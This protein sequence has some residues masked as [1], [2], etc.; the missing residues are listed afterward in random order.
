MDEGGVKQPYYIATGSS[1][2]DDRTRVLKYGDMFAIFNRYGDIETTGLDEQGIFY[3]G[4]RIL[5][6]LEVYLGN[7]K[8]LLLS[9]TVKQDNSLFTADLS[10]VDLSRDGTVV[11]PRDTLHLERRQFLWRG[12]CYQ[13]FELFNYGLNPVDIGLEI[14]FAADFADIFEVRGTHRARKGRPLPPIVEE[15]GVV[16]G[17]EGL[18]GKLR[19]TRLECR[20]QPGKTTGSSFFFDVQL[21]PR[22]Q[23]AITL[24]IA[25]KDHTGEGRYVFDTALRASQA[26]HVTEYKITSSNQEFNDWI[27][28]SQ[29]DIHMM[30][31]GNPERDYPYAGV[32]WFSTVFGRDGIIT[33][34]QYLWLDPAVACGV[35]EFLAS[36]QAT[37][38]SPKTE[39]QPGKI[40]HEMRRGEMAALG[41][42]PFARYYGT[43]DATP[44]FVMLA[45]AYHLRTGD[46][47]FIRRLWP[48]LLKAL[49]WVDQYGDA[50]GDGF[51]EYSRQSNQGLLHQG[52]KDSN[53]SVF[54]AD[55]TAAEPPIALC[56]VQGYV[57]AAKCG[58]ARLA[59]LLAE[60]A[61]AERLESEALKLRARFHQAFWCP[62]LSCYAIALDGNKQRCCVRTSN[63][64]HSLFTGIADREIA[65]HLANLL[66]GSDFFSGWGIRTVACNEVRYNPISYHNGSIWPH[67]NAIIA[68]G[69][70]R[71]GFKAHAGK[72]LSTLLETSRFMDLHRLPELFCGLDRRPGEGPTSYPVACAPQAWAAGSVFMLLQACLGLS[73]DAERKQ[74]HFDKPYLPDTIP[75]LWIRDLKVA[76]SAVDLQ[77]D[78]HEDGARVQVIRKRGDLAII[79]A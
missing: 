56:E 38:I 4:T 32:P 10:N 29:S 34:L 59:R 60:N 43:V 76:D 11:V 37:Q 36:T 20:P 57:Y 73:F 24:I 41:E 19:Q 69:F 2:A 63:A 55:G 22:T 61:Q 51:V 18:D 5:S 14:V 66:A 79:G 47:D 9:S 7:A 46:H 54:H 50:D 23:H 35:L 6:Q 65:P 78:R 17:Y 25:C 75:Q 70:S 42:V 72:I 30:L 40:L 26:A 15:D 8:P 74:I 13:Q 49:Q 16:L 28:R 31:L 64:G 27:R 52:W 44:L 68:A 67:D 71:Y 62:Q 39:A 12:V 3:E 58:M 45:D 21:R 48:N 33:A 1:P 53:D 77:V